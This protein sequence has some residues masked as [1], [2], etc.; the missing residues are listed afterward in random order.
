MTHT[1]R[2]LPAL[3]LI[4]LAAVASAPARANDAEYSNY[5]GSPAPVQ[6]DVVRMASETISFTQRRGGW[7]VEAKYVFENTSD[8][9]V[10][11]T[12]GYPEVERDNGGRYFEQLQTRVR[13][14]PIE[15]TTKKPRPLQRAP[16]SDLSSG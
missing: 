5:S 9:A 15:V 16:R 13:G 14:K 8:E 6:N 1:G 2:S 12:M 10:S 3:V 11:L 7:D 4:A